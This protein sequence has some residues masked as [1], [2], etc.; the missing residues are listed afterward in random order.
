VFSATFGGLI[1]CSAIGIIIQVIFWPTVGG[2]T[3]F[4]SNYANWQ[5]FLP[6]TLIMSAFNAFLWSSIGLLLT[7]KTW[8]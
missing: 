5:W 1:L 8:D 3:L 2:V 6:A 7:S 4:F